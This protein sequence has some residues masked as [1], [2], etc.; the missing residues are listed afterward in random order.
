[1]FT[2]TYHMQQSD[3]EQLKKSKRYVPRK[4]QLLQWTTGQPAPKVLS[5]YRGSAVVDGNRAYLSLVNAIYS[6]STN[7]NKWFKLPECSQSYFGLVMVSEHLVAIGG[8]T[9][10]RTEGEVTNILVGLTHSKVWDDIL[11][12]MPT[13]R[14]FP[15][16]ATISE[17]LVVAGGKIAPESEGLVTVEILDLESLQWSTAISLLV[18]LE[19]PQLVVCENLLYVTDSESSQVHACSVNG[20]IPPAEQPN[21]SLAAN[22]SSSSENSPSQ[23][24]IRPSSAENEENTTWKRISNL[25]SKGGTRI[26]T[27]GGQLLALGGHDH[28][29]RPSKIVACYDQESDTWKTVGALSAPK[30]GFLAVSLPNRKIMVAGGNSS[31]QENCDSTDIASLNFEL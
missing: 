13:K 31:A 7:T 6:F 26:I 21:S 27:E 16:A 4:S 14:A 22:G 5:G 17:H 12:P 3:T 15:A 8:I 24:S 10:R 30:W 28:K 2:H 19:H 18:P 1:M 11:P 23:A 9:G 20:V 25:P 29:Y